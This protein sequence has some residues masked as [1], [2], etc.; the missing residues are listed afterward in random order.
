MNRMTDQLDTSTEQNDTD[1]PPHRK[2]PYLVIGAVLWVMCFAVL[3]LVLI[4]VRQKSKS[5]V[6]E[7]NSSQSREDDGRSVPTMKLVPTSDGNFNLQKVIAPGD[8]D[9]WDAAGIGDFSF[10]DCH[11]Q[12]VTKSDLLGK[13]FVIGFVFTNCRGPCPNVTLQMRE[14][15]NRLKEYEFNLITLTV[16]PERDTAGVLL[17]YAKAQGADFD[18]WKFLT[19]PQ[20][21]IYRLIQFSFKMPVKEVTG[22]DRVPGFEI[23]HSRN[24]MIVDA[25]GRVR[26]KFDVL[27]DEDMARLR[28]ELKQLAKRVDNNRDGQGEGDSR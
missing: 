13:P 22:D 12:T 17:D 28:K 1:G 18:R 4:Q 6:S 20:L 23:V 7:A 5:L 19:G 2:R 10:T 25:T 8:D 9:L 3:V 24:L 15:Q 27:K 21:D 11:G 16:D 14:L 26:G